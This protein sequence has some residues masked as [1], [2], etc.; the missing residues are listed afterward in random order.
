MRRRVAIA[1]ELGHI[2]LGHEL[3]AG[4]YGHTFNSRKPKAEEQAD[5]FAARLLCLACVLRGLD[6]HT[7]ADIEKVCIISIAE[8]KKRAERMKLLYERQKFLTSPLERKLFEQ[9]SNYI[10]ENKIK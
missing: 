8:A 5:A 10:S 2:F 7:V 6:I 9:F 4:I 1:H 3:T